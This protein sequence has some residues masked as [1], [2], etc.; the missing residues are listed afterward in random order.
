MSARLCLLFAAISGFLVVATGAFA[1][2]MLK[3]ALSERL[4]DVLQ[5]GVQ[6]Q[7]FHTLALLGVGIL[8]KE[9]PV[10]LLR[11][12]GLLFVLGICLFCG[13]LYLLALTGVH[14]LGAVTP[15]GGMMFLAG[16]FC[17]GLAVFRFKTQ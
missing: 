9:M 3:P 12:S 17:A 1:A 6:Y 14:W 8:M 13:S 5:T 2:H 7:M 15:I 11:L 16:W 10:R 4:Y